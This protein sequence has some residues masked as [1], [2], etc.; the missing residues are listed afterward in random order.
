MEYA[1]FAEISENYL[2]IKKII[3]NLS[4]DNFEFMSGEEARK[5]KEDILYELSID[6][7]FK[8]LA[9]FEAKLR[10]DYNI[11][12]SM[13]KKDAL[14]K[15]YMKLCRDH[16]KKVNNYNTPLETLCRRVRF[17]HLLDVVH[18]FLKQSGVPIHRD[19]SA[20]KGHLKFRHWYAHGRYFKHIPSVP[21]P[22]DLEY[23]CNEI[24]LAVE[25]RV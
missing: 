7:S 14:S 15:E 11:V 17:D 19:C 8:H 25:N 13:Q 21:D 10:T 6:T 9:M 5:A 12:L 20:L 3:E 22:E 1:S 18:Q 16:R 2:F 4:D 23:V 24:I